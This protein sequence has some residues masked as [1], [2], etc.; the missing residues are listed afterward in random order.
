MRS[1]VFAVLLAVSLSFPCLAQRDTNITTRASLTVYVAFTNERA[2][3]KSIEVRVYQRGQI[4]FG[5]SFTDERGR[6]KFDQVPAGYYHV[7]VQGTGIEKT[8]GPEFEI[9]D[10]EG[11]TPRRFGRSRRWMRLRADHTSPAGTG[12]CFRN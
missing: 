5:E 10:M 9:L 1:V 2:L 12:H 4:L 6:A 3:G 11:L 8:E 7:E